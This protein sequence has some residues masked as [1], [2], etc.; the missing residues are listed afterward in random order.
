[1]LTL[2]P[3]SEVESHFAD[4]K[5]HTKSDDVS[6]VISTEVLVAKGTYNH[7][8]GT[9][10]TKESNKG[11]ALNSQEN[12]EPTTQA[13]SEAPES[14]KIRLST[15][16]TDD[17]NQ[18]SISGSTQLS[19]FQRLNTTAKKVQSTSPTP[20]TR[21]SAFK[22][23]SVLVTRGQKKPLI[24]VSRKP[25]LVIRD[26]E[27][28]SVVPSRMKTNMFFSVN[29]ESLLKIKRYYVVFTRPKNNEL[30]DE[31]DVAGC[32]HVTIE[33]ASDHEAFEEDAKATPLSLEDGGQSMIDEL[34]E[35]DLGTI[36]EARPTF[37]SA[38]LS[39]D[40]EN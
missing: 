20:V 6:K 2:R 35:V 17:Q 1:M 31:V 14:E 11:N 7:K 26:E 5:F 18:G 27:I 36:E 40:D 4:A 12:D 13:K 39:D 29:T 24:S 15:S 34:K 9:I 38:Q 32:S 23:L 21:E 33:E 25:G 8:Q 10:T 3:F 37:I 28:H 16:T 22:R 19:A 30:E